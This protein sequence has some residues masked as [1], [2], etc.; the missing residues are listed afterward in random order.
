MPSAGAPS[1]CRPDRF[2]AIGVYFVPN[3][4]PLIQLPSSRRFQTKPWHRWALKLLGSGLALGVVYYKVDF[5]ATWAALKEMSVATFLAAL[6]LYNLSKAFGAARYRDLLIGLGQRRSLPTHLR[7]NYA[8]M[9]YSLFLPGSVAGD[10]F[11][12][13]ALRDA[14]RG[15]TWQALTRLSVLDRFSGVAALGL[16]LPPLAAWGSAA[17]RLGIYAWGLPLLMIAGLGAYVWI[18]R[19]WLGARGG[20]WPRALAWSFGVQAAQLGG[21][22]LALAGMGVAQ[23]WADYLLLFLLSS[24]ATLVPFTLGGAGARELV[25]MASYRYAGLSSEVAVGLGL[26]FFILT[27]LTALPGAWLAPSR[28][29]LARADATLAAA[30]PPEPP[31]SQS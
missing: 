7:L 19:R 9:F 14:D 10:A 29:E 2:F 21:A 12:V 25:F 8:A 27:V 24:L 30:P 1:S 20:M 31:Q 4:R 5:A 13:Y 3:A 16:L 26:L 6:V 11:K 23:Q 22:W 17:P 18:A 15:I 28:A